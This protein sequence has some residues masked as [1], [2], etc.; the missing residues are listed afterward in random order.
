MMSPITTISKV[1]DEYT[2]F[3]NIISP[4][5][6]SHG[7]NLDSYEEYLKQIYYSDA[8]ELY[9]NP[10]HKTF[11]SQSILN[12]IGY[13]GEDRKRLEKFK[14]RLLSEFIE[15]SDYFIYT[16]ENIPEEFIFHGGKGIQQN[17]YI[18]G[19]CFTRCLMSA[20]TNKGKD[21]RKF[22]SSLK[23]SFDAYIIHL[24]NTHLTQESNKLI[25]AE[26]E[27]SLVLSK[28][29][30][31]VEESCEQVKR[32]KKESEQALFEMKKTRINN[33]LSQRKIDFPFTEHIYSAKDNSSIPDLTKV[34]RT[35]NIYART[36]TMNTSRIDPLVLKAFDVPFGLANNVEERLHFFLEPYKVNHEWFNLPEERVEKIIKKE[37]DS[38]KE[39]YSLVKKECEEFN[40]EIIKN[41][42]DERLKEKTNPP[43]LIP[44]SKPLSQSKPLPPIPPLP[45]QNLQKVS[46]TIVKMCNGIIVSGE[47]K[48]KSCGRIVKENSTK[49]GF[50][51]NQ[52]KNTG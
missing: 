7:I 43:K 21:L 44:Q 42:S 15:D 27:K 45:Q 38:V 40:E 5:M 11:V 33:I 28:K 52:N 10:S 29:L 13:I 31:E 34:G 17:I 18:T 20:D 22:L 46:K 14:R 8:K 24:H 1:S 47:K 6:D 35:Q 32:E 3:K 51:L 41:N 25:E 23:Y 39:L 30:I 37:I 49:C 26:K 48:G 9:M 16:R 50:H 19:D 2:S 4:I 36:A 12:F